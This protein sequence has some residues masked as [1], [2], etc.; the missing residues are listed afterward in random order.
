M[1]AAHPSITSLFGGPTQINTEKH[2]FE[3]CAGAA[4]YIPSHS[5]TLKH[6]ISKNRDHSKSDTP[7]SVERTLPAGNKSVAGLRAVNQDPLDAGRVYIEG[8][9][10]LAFENPKPK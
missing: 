6:V 5:D 1:I 7:R 10:L 8:T 4:V 2:A 3:E 9:I